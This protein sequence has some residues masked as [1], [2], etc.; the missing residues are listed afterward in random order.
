[1]NGIGVILYTLP[2]GVILYTL[3]TAA[4]GKGMHLACTP[5]GMQSVIYGEYKN[6]ISMRFAKVVFKCILP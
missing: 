2:T 5:T 1:M 6:V 4:V 3:P